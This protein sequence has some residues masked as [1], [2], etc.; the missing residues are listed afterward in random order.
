MV[1][2]NGVNHGDSSMFDIALDG[3]VGDTRLWSDDVPWWM[4]DNQ[5]PIRPEDGMI[6]WEKLSLAER[7]V[8]RVVNSWLRKLC[9]VEGAQRSVSP[10]TPGIPGPRGWSMPIRQC[11]AWVKSLCGWYSPAN[12]WGFHE[13]VGEDTFCLEVEVDKETWLMLRRD[14]VPWAQTRE[15]RRA[16]VPSVWVEVMAWRVDHRLE[17]GEQVQL[18]TR[19]FQQKG[20]AT[21]ASADSPLAEGAPIL[22]RT[23]D[24]DLWPDPMR[25]QDRPGAGALPS[26]ETPVRVTEGPPWWQDDSWWIGLFPR[27]EE[28]GPDLPSPIAHRLHPVVRAYESVEAYRHLLANW[29]APIKQHSR[30]LIRRFTDSGF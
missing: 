30:R 18:P 14:R 13:V 17:A 9:G 27:G 7:D 4:S 15:A 10:P 1:L 21:T 20:Q 8:V 29:D 26:V 25:R 2:E 3:V 24:A 22:F 16:W 28:N 6:D 23:I 19:V 12:V 11:H 5:Y